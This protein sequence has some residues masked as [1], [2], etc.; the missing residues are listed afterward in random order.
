MSGTSRGV[1]RPAGADAEE[2]RQRIRVVAVAHFGRYGYSRAAIKGI[3]EEAG[4]TSGSVHYHF[5]SKQRLLED[6]AAWIA[7]PVAARLEA[8]A[9]QPVEFGARVAALLEEVVAVCAELPDFARF[10]LVLIADAARDPALRVA[11]AHT[12][13][14]Y[15]AVYARLVDD[16]VASGQLTAD[17]D[18]DA[19][20]DLLHGVVAGLISLTVMRPT[21]VVPARYL[22]CAQMLVA[23]ELFAA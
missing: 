1:G 10:T 16:A 19:V 23:G 5:E 17:V 21:T 22:R 11:Y 15:E 7:A 13:N 20:T 18:R 3:A 14:A 8:A 4:V 12:T 2:T 9:A 6:A